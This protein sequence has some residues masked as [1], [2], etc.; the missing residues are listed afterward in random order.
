[1][2]CFP[3]SAPPPPCCGVDRTFVSLSVD[4]EN[5]EASRGKSVPLSIYCGLLIEYGPTRRYFLL[6]TVG[7]KWANRCSNSP[8][9]MSE[10][11]LSLQ[12]R[13][14]SSLIPLAF[15]LDSISSP[16][17]ASP[18]LT[19]SRRV[20]GDKCWRMPSRGCSLACRAAKCLLYIFV[21]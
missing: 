3:R 7:N 6:L 14:T 20:W 18:K 16:R 9:G 19:S 1:M 17:A 12:D 21:V 15:S 13:P 8:Q 11:R 10:A 4:A 2:E 5:L